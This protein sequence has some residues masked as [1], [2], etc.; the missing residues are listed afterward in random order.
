MKELA[1]DKY[2]ALLLVV[3]LLASYVYTRDAVL[4]T[5][6]I[7]ATGGFLGLVRSGSTNISGGG[8]APGITSQHGPASD[9]TISGFG[10]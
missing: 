1:K 5:L 4:Q 7:T 8:N 2:L 3:I 6:L 10:V 9:A